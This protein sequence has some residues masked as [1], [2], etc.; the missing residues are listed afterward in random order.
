[1][2]FAR[3]QGS[4]FVQLET[5]VDNFTAQQLYESIG[6]VKQAADTDF[7]LYKIALNS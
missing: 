6:F 1:M 5:A 4:T 7:F 2:D 3:K